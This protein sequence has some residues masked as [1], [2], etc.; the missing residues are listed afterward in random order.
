MLD[1]SYMEKILKVK[2][3]YSK[4]IIKV[5]FDTKVIDVIKLMHENH[6]RNIF[7]EKE[8]KLIGIVT[9]KEIMKG[10]EKDP[11][12]VFH[13]EIMK[14][15]KNLEEIDINE[16]IFKSARI[17]YDKDVGILVVKEN[18]KIIGKVGE[19]D[20]L[21]SIPYLKI[22]LRVIDVMSRDVEY[23]YPENTIF[24]ALVI[25]NKRKSRHVPVV[26]NNR[27]VGMF[28]S[29]D[30][31][32]IF[33]KCSNEEEVRKVINIQVR[34]EM[35]IDPLTID[36]YAFIVDAANLMVNKNIGALP[37]IDIT[38]IIGIITERDMIKILAQTKI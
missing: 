30:I 23:V 17:M 15:A 21:L 33:S 18:N 9:I 10:I 34:K 31:L 3:Y 7:I 8:G 35:K 32:R 6:I 12:I 16:T 27:L 29:R 22:E 2:N 28:S 13:N 37:V 24:D 14:L 26:E 11:S 4:F 1:K 25:M 36:P 38:K 19:R 5:K 20:L